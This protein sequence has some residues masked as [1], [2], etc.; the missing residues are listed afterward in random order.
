[1]VRISKWVLPAAALALLAAIALWPEFDRESN[2]ARVAFRRMTTAMDGA[3]LV[4]ARYRG[5]D[6][7]GRPY[8]VTAEIA[9]QVGPERVNLTT[10]KGDITLENGTWMLLQSKQGVFMQHA[11][12]L[13][14]SHEVFLYRDD[15]T[16]M[17]T[18]AATIDLKAGA[19]ASA[20]RTHAEGPFGV[21]DADGGFTLTDKGEVVQ[22]AGPAKLVLNGSKE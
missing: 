21:L 1:M 22:F 9:Q 19:A 13:D 5:V 4:D 16:T 3:T 8:T 15:G 11:N 17:R 6:E 14:L 7:R 2:E 12:Q 10:P 18:E 20:E